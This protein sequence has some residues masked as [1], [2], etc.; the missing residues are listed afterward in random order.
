M[1]FNTESNSKEYKVHYVGWSNKWDEIVPESRLKIRD[2]SV[3]Y[4]ASGTPEV[5]STELEAPQTDGQIPVV[6]KAT[7]KQAKSAVQR[8]MRQA[9]VCNPNLLIM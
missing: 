7:K 1:R 5:H 3:T 9:F 6:K 4:E 2:D 8:Y